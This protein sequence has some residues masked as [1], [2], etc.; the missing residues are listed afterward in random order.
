MDGWMEQRMDG[1][2]DGRKEGRKEE[3]PYVKD[4]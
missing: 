3:H 2:M 1:W 4:R